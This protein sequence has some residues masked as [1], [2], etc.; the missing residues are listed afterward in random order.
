MLPYLFVVLLTQ[1]QSTATCGFFSQR[2]GNLEIPCH[3]V[4]MWVKLIRTTE[5]PINMHTVC[6]ALSGLVR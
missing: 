2:V 6:C 3:D 5:Y 1:F 4:I